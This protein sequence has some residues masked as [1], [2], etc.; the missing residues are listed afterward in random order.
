MSQ[1][2][3]VGAAMQIK[4]LRE[5]V[6]W[7]KEEQR[8]LEIQDF[9]MWSAL[10][11]DWRW[12][13]K[14]V[15]SLL[16]GYTG[17]MG[18][19]G[20]FS[21]PGVEGSWDPAIRAVVTSR[22]KQAFEVINEIGATHMVVHNPFV[23]LGQTYMPNT[24]TMAMERLFETMGETLSGILPLA[25]A[26]NCT[27]V[28]ENIWDSAPGLILALIK[29]LKSDHVKMSIDI[30]HAYIAHKL[31]AVSLDFWIQE[32]GSMLGHVHLQDTDGYSD[33]HWMPGMGDIHWGVISESIQELEETPRLILEVRGNQRQAAD[34][35]IERGYFS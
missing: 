7:I 4:H 30:G 33:R 27:I 12:M 21:S 11:G 18:I 22:F 8:D 28:I 10:D 29:S 35:L 16:D 23:F 15:K 6:D 34:W 32:A 17:R 19:H 13:A 5:H 25:K 1:L 26:A 20:P 2:P 9:A 3:K 24:E 31:G 14:E